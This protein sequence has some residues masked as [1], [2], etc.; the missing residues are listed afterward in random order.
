MAKSGTQR[1]AFG[2]SIG[3]TAP[4]NSLKVGYNEVGIGLF[5]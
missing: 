3:L 5:S 4:Y 2:A 1:A